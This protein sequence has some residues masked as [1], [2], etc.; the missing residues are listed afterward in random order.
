[1]EIAI[2]MRNPATPALF[3]PNYP[4]VLVSQ[5]LLLLLYIIN[6]EGEQEKKIRAGK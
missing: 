4:I 2:H 1:M 6:N 5:H 3:C